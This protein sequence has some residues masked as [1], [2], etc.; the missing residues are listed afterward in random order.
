MRVALALL[1]LAICPSA[2]SDQTPAATA[3]FRTDLGRV[4]AAIMEARLAKDICA[5][6]FPK[7]SDSNETAY[8]E[9]RRKHA[10]FLQ[11]IETEHAALIWDDAQ[12]QPQRHLAALGQM[13]DIVVRQKKS[14][15]ETLYRGG[16]E[17]LRAQCT[18]F[19]VYLTTEKMN[20]EA[21]YAQQANTIRA[22]DRAR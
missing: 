4:H 13:D 8:A 7:L 9:W 11:R 5:E 16:T 10:G 2:G 6:V 19:P 18:L 3:D 17:A 15:R 1:L 21:F 20:L 12:H 14:L 22:H